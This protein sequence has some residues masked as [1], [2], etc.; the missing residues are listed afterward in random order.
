MNETPQSRPRPLAEFVALMAL[1]T[2]LVALST[3]AML[4]ALPQIGG[5]LGVLQANNN[6]FVLTS[7]FLGLALG[8]MFFGPL[9]DSVGRKPAISAGLLLF[10]VGC[11]LSV[12][13]TDFS[14]MLVGRVLQGVGV[15]GPRTV[16][17][18]LVR[19]Q[20]EGRAMAR[21]MSFVMAV[22]ILVPVAAPALGQG[23]LYVADWRFIFV[24]FL[25]L[26]TLAF[27]WLAVRQ[28]E[29]LLPDRRRVL[30]LGRIGRA[31]L[32]VCTNRIAFSNAAAAGSFFPG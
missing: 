14:T 24:T 31:V 7:F 8:Q 10:I 19:D 26:A 18:A 22:F 21:I 2:S 6:Q 3:D 23:I 17:V 27:I 29:T 13:A 12:I 9:S 32:E 30:S 4:P 20:Y 11:L 25:A 5:D 28:P 16:S 1:L 15:A